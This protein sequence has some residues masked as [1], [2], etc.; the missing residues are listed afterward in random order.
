MKV[1]SIFNN[2]LVID[3]FLKDDEL[4]NVWLELDFLTNKSIMLP[5]EKYN[6]ARD[7]LT[8]VILKKNNVIFLDDIYQ[9]RETSNILTNFKKLYSKEVVDII[10]DLPNEFKYFKF[11]GHDR[12][13]ISYYEDSDYYKPHVD[14]AVLTCLYWCNKSPKLFEGGNL[15]IGDEQTQIEYKNNR[16]VIFPSYNIHSVDVIKMAEDN[17]PFSG[18]G[19]YTITKFLFVNPKS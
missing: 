11:V 13:F 10:E 19:R 16:L 3:D 17:I 12:T 8:N 2:Y 14:Q 4:K 9:N 5:P 6:S 15:T 7:K 18:W 1:T